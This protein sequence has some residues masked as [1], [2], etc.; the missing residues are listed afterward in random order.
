MSRIYWNNLQ[1]QRKAKNQMTRFV[2]PDIFF[3]HCGTLIWS[4]VLLEGILLY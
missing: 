2:K 3:V 1:T 4:I